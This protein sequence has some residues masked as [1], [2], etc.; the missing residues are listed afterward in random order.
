M[1]KRLLALAL[2]AVVLVPAG[3]DA[4]LGD[5]PWLERRVWN[6]AH[7]GGEN[8]APS[9]TLYAFKTA[10]IKGA[11]MLELD[12]LA[13]KDGEN[14]VLNYATVDRKTNGS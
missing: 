5:N 14:F 7:Q 8:E 10:L 1:I 12:V 6:I 13:T 3:G 4:A 9:D 2:A 11:D